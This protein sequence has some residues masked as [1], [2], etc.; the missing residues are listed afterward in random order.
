MKKTPARL[1]SRLALLVVLVALGYLGFQISALSQPDFTTQAALLHTVT[2]Q[3]TVEGIFLRTEQ[4][5]S[6]SGSGSG[7]LCYAR[8]SGERVSAG[9]LLATV[10]QNAA[11][12]DT[13]LTATELD[14]TIEQL[15]SLIARPGIGV[16]GVKETET[17]IAALLRQL[18]ADSHLG[19][20]HDARQIKSQ[21]IYETSRR[22]MAVGAF[23]DAASL[24]EQLTARRAALSSTLSGSRQVTAPVSGFFLSYSDGYE[25][26]FD[27]SLAGSL[28]VQDIERLR[29]TPPEDRSDAVGKLVHGYTWYFACPADKSLA[30]RLTAGRSYTLRFAYD[31]LTDIEATLDS[32]YASGEDGYVLTFSSAQI[33]E[34]LLLLRS[35]TA[36]ILLS[37]HEGLRIPN[38]ARRV[39]DG[40][41]GVYI[42]SGLTFE[43]RPIEVLYADERWSIVK[44]EPNKSGRLKLYDEVVVTGKDLYDG[45]IVAN[46]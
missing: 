14:A 35:H 44:W 22:Q 26:I 18:T 38:E 46:R 19:S 8:E 34:E 29:A 33:T 39:V 24:H 13:G 21:L 1:L 16:S 36:E 9:G 28:T 20:A 42:R 12:L 10:Y 32:I 31:P 3:A 4:P 41:T 37:E 17:A 7:Y 11:Q 43:F 40:V 6:L 27:A 45:K 2:D 25:T 30:S 23:G 5:V 15:A